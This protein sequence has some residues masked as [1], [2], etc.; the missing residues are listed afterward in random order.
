MKLKIKAWDIV[1]LGV[2]LL[3]IMVVIGISLLFGRFSL[4]EIDAD[5]VAELT[6]T[7]L[8][9]WSEYRIRVSSP[10]DIETI[11]QAFNDLTVMEPALSESYTIM[12]GYVYQF[13]FVFRDGTELIIYVNDGRQVTLVSPDGDPA[14]DEDYICDPDDASAFRLFFYK[15]GYPLEKLWDGVTDGPKKMPDK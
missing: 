3:F 7:R 8:Q 15:F 12:G 5:E 1:I 4:V 6:I 11:S 13:A 14:K 2:P 9:N 10:D